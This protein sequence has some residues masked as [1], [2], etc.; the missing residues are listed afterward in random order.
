MWSARDVVM[1]VRAAL[2]AA[3]NARLSDGSPISLNSS[4]VKHLS[5]RLRAFE[6]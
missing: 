1:L 2:H 4:A 6:K 5:D 3:M